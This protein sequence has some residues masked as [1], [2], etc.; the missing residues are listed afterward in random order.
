MGEKLDSIEKKKRVEKK[1]QVQQRKK[2]IEAKATRLEDERKLLEAEREEQKKKGVVAEAE[3]KKA[4]A[5]AAA[6]VR[7]DPSD[8]S[9]TNEGRAAA[10]AIDAATNRGKLTRQL[11]DPEKV[12]EKAEAKALAHEAEEKRVIALKNAMAARNRVFVDEK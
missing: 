6:V 11:K 12:R 7:G 1:K 2:E 5:A 9:L 3:V 10:N 8:P 4:R